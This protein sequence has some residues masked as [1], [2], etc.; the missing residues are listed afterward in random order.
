MLLNDSYRKWLKKDGVVFSDI[1]D[2]NYVSISTSFLDSNFD[3]ITLYARIIDKN[4]IELSD[5]G[6]TLFELEEAGVCLN[7]RSKTTWNLFQEALNNFG[8][9]QKDDALIIE[10]SLNKFPIAKSRLLQAILRINDLRYLSKTNIQSS[11]NDMLSNYFR[12]NK[13]L[14]SYNIEIANGDGISSHFDFSI[15]S[16]DKKEKLV[17]TVGRPNDTNQA[18]VFN[19]DVKATSLV[20]DANYILILDDENHKSSIEQD[21]ISTALNGLNEIDATVIGSSELKKTPGL[22]SN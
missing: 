12:N 22:I 16:N 17:K 6:N 4:R 19:Y 10:T 21:T 11:F 9:K 18:K 15:P 5:F 1:D 7:K 8:V 14:F 13:V 20:R 3:N 2:D